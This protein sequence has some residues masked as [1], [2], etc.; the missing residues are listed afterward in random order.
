MKNCVRSYFKYDNVTPCRY[1]IKQCHKHYG[2]R[3]ED[4]GGEYRKSSIR[5][6]V[7]TEK[8]PTDFC[9]AD[10]ISR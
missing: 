7:I 8:A 2:E 10:P 6:F 3:G 1:Y 5:R 9:V 4:S